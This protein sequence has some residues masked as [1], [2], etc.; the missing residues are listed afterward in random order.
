VIAPAAP[1]EPEQPKEFTCPE[2]LGVT[3]EAFCPACG[4]KVRPVKRA[5]DYV[6]DVRGSVGRYMCR[7]CEY[8]SDGPLCPVCGTRLSVD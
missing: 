3:T 8:M 2:C 1:E 5:D 7:T 4:I 6:S